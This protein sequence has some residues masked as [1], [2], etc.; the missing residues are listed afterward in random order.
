VPDPQNLG[1]YSDRL[2]EIGVRRAVLVSPDPDAELEAMS[3]WR[4]VA[5]AEGLPEDVVV[6]E[7]D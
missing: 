4:V 5:R 7:H 1:R 2:A 3:G 6:I